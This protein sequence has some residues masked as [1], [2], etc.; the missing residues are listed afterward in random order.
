MRE[1]FGRQ[2]ETPILQLRP[3][4]L[5][6]EQISMLLRASAVVKP[7]IRKFNQF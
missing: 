1:V 5:Q 3:I 6:F 4:V 2:G 7:K